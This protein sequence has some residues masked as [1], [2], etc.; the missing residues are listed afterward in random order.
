MLE[1]ELKII[2]GFLTDLD[3]SIHAKK[4][5]KKSC[6]TLPLRSVHD[7]CYM[8]TASLSWVLLKD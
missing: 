4:G 8:G 1:K 3:L 2:R 6:E 5:P 7:S